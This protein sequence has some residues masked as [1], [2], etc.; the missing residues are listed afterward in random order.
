MG[1]PPLTRTL[2][3]L[4]S[5]A[6][7]AGALAACDNNS[8][9]ANADLIAG[10]RAFVK[11]CGSCHTLSRAGTKGTQGPNLDDAFRESLSEGFGR[12][13]VRGV[14]FRQSQ[15]PA[16][17]P[18]TSPVIM[19]AKLVHGK[20]AHDVAA[21]VASVVALPGKDVGRLGNAVAVAGAGKPVA[22]SGGKLLMP[23]DPTGQLAYVTKKATAPAGPLEIDSK[24]ASSTPHDIA[25]EGNGLKQ[26]DGKT[27]SNG[28][29]STIK[30]NL[31]PGTYT[32]FCTLPGHRAAGMQGTLTVK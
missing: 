16:R 15:Q 6:T 11:S 3:A 4:A 26:E 18:K 17:L 5:G 23:A 12:N 30:V 13:T 10:K 28:A 27:V 8:A 24:N 22:A 19:P 1:R 14:V 21:Y 9:P 2:I 20:L 32:Y 31:K 25:I 29:V 7:L